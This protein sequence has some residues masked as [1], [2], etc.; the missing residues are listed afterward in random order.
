MIQVSGYNRLLGEKFIGRKFKQILIVKCPENGSKWS[1]V[2]I[3]FCQ[4]ESYVVQIVLCG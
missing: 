2:Q 4:T 1:Y 3:M